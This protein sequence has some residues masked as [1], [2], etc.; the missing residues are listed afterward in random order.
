MSNKNEQEEEKVLYS[1]SSTS[2]FKILSS[3]SEIINDYDGFILDQFGVIHNGAHALDGAIDLVTELATTPMSTAGT[4]ASGTN[5]KSETS[6]EDS[7]NKKIVILSNSSVPSSATMKKLERLGFQQ[8]HFAA[9][10]TSGQEAGKFVKE[11]YQGKK[12]LF[13]TWKSAKSSTSTSTP[14]PAKIFLELCGDIQIVLDP[15]EA[16]FILLNG[17][18]V[19]RGPD[20]NDDKND[21][22]EIS[23]GSFHVDENFEKIDPILKLCASRDVPMICANPDFI[24]VKPDETIGH[25]PGKIAQRYQ[26]TFHATTCHRFGKPYVEHFHACLHA[27]GIVPTTANDD[28]DDNEESHTPHH[29]SRQ[30]QHQHERR[31]PRPRVVHVGD[32]LHHDIAGANATGIDSVFVANGIHRQELVGTEESGILIPTRESLQALFTKY[33][34]TPTY[35]ISMFRR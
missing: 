5:K 32:S 24:M 10:I 8:N 16:D 18:D 21:D 4:A 13:M 35:V 28:E 31:R 9:A 29:P 7:N 33:S 1:S 14:S 17:V 12:A 15:N 22:N 3:F 30:H 27:L 11:H 34:Q 25:M 2:S 26:D 19:I 23:L 20:G 6:V